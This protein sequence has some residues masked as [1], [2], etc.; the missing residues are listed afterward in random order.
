MDS[1]SIASL[2]QD[3]GGLTVTKNVEE[4]ITKSKREI[5]NNAVTEEKKIVCLGLA[6]K[7]NEVETVAKLEDED[8]P[9][10]ESSKDSW[11]M[12]VNRIQLDKGGDL[13]GQPNKDSADMKAR[14][15]AALQNQDETW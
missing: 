4:L 14:I 10:V 7:N 15:R 11:T 6:T 1:Y 8:E 3:G 12:S 13:N 2:V 5:K 9:M